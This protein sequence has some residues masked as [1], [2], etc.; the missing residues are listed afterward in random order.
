MST[1][2]PQPQTRSTPTWL[3]IIGG[4][5]TVL[6][7]PLMLNRIAQVSGDRQKEADARGRL[8]TSFVQAV[9]STVTASRLFATGLIV[10]S[11]PAGA[12]ASN[13]SLAGAS[14]YAA[15]LDSWLDVS[16]QVGDDVNN[17]F[18]DAPC[19]PTPPAQ[20]LRG[21]GDRVR[22]DWIYLFSAV[23]DYLRIASHV[24]PLDAVAAAGRLQAALT[25]LDPLAKTVTIDWAAL[26]TRGT[27]AD[28][29]GTIQGVS[30]SLLRARDQYAKDVRG[31][32]ADG[33][34]L[35]YVYLPWD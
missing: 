23:T 27:A 32:R 20:P 25:A 34:S 12:T 13:S 29:V 31:S 14:A 5:L 15:T 9:T 21:R 33:Y 24:E 7:V 10:A 30:D 6:I 3:K 26:K 18:G 4:V 17:Y 2:S 1:V 11:A 8:L 22:C 35:R 28:W 16:S 19:P